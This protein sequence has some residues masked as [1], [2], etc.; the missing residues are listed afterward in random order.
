L[1]KL[2]IDLMRQLKEV[3][4]QKYDSGSQGQLLR[5]ICE[6]SYYMIQQLSQ[7]KKTALRDRIKCLEDEISQLR[8]KVTDD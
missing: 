4:D 1:K 2:N 5:Q 6:S 8:K 3:S 7:S